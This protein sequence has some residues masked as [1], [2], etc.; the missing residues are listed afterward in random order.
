MDRL[1][2]AVG[3]S[4]K[5]FV[6]LLSG[7]ACAI[8]GIMATRTM[9]SSR[10]RLRTIFVLPFMSCAARLPVYTLLIGAF[11]GTYSAFTQGALMLSL[12]VLGIVA[13]FATAW[14]WKSRSREASSSFMLELPTYKLPRVSNVLRVVGR[15]TWAF[16]AKAGTIIFALSVILWAMTYWPRLPESRAAEVAQSAES[17]WSE[18]TAGFSKDAALEEREEVTVH[19]VSTAEELI[20]KELASAQLRHSLA[21]R[22]GRLIEPVIAPLGFDWKMGVGLV[23]AFA[24]RE[25]FVSTMGIVYAQGDDEHT[26][27]LAA[28]MLADR[29][30]DGS[31]V[32]TP[33]I[34]I[35]L[36]IWFVIA[37][38][39]I[40]TVA[41]VKRETNGWR[42]PILQL[43]YMNALAWVLCFIVFQ[44]GS[45]LF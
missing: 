27:P 2:S 6:P 8:P 11:F 12:Y 44:I 38:Q 32:W 16:V 21:G 45:R 24:A 25:V 39:C 5:A 17:I 10:D 14:V 35:N 1:L 15:S 33:L 18:A 41:I 42:W 19:G 31:P 22:L 7:F 26:E 40:S 9:E 20:E 13:A 23:G 36:L 28:A 30:P 3:L 4:G 29:Y 43:L 37:M 34:A